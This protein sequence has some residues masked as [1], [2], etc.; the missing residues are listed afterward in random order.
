MRRNEARAVLNQ[1]MTNEIR[2]ALS[3]AISHGFEKYN[4]IR[5][6]EDYD[7]LGMYKN[8]QAKRLLYSCVCRCLEDEIN[9]NYGLIAECERNT[10]SYKTYIHNDDV[11]IDVFDEKHDNKRKF[12]NSRFSLNRK[13][14]GKKYIIIIYYGDKNTGTLRRMMIRIYNSVRTLIYEEDLCQN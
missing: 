9:G 8:N 5:I 14:A 6:S 2:T 11:V 13:L 7:S 3:T 12:Q 4:R 10:N 1:I